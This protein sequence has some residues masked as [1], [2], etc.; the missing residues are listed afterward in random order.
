MYKEKTFTGHI[1]EHLKDDDGKI[2]EFTFVCYMKANTLEE[3]LAIIGKIYSILEGSH[4]TNARIT[5]RP[6]GD[7]IFIKGCLP[8]SLIQTYSLKLPALC[9]IYRLDGIREMYACILDNNGNYSLSLDENMNITKS[10]LA[11]GGG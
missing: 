2:R 10:I 1:R 6:R 4:C 5:I 9:D 8:W 11:E 3:R 7:T